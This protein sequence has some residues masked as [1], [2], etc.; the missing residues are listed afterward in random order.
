MPCPAHITVFKSD[1]DTFTGGVG[2]F[3][4]HVEVGPT[5]V[6]AGE[7]VTVRM[8]ISGEG[9]IKQITPPKLEEDHNLKLYEAR[10]LPSGKANEVVFEQVIIPAT[11]TVTNIP[12]IAFTYFNTKTADFRTL[13]EGPFPIT[14]EARPQRAA[15]I[16]ATVPS[17]IRQETEILGRDI[18]YLKSI[19]DRW[20]SAHE[21]RW[22]HARLFHLA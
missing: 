3:D 21:E 1:T 22:Y 2:I 20:M 8:R 6:K 13:T 12:P 15:Q 9:N 19:P 14:V 10:T 5:D 16:I 18:V 7:P 4:F 11:E 17:S